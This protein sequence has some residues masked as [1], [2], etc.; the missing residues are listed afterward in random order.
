MAAKKTPKSR[1]SQV[2]DESAEPLGATLCV[3]WRAT[4]ILLTKARY[5]GPECL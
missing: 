3:L 5:P 2:K 1:P 4:K